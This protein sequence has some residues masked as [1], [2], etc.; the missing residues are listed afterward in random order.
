[1][2]GS[3]HPTLQIPNPQL[4]DGDQWV[5]VESKVHGDQTSAFHHGELVMELKQ[6]RSQRIYTDKK[7]IYCGCGISRC[8]SESIQWSS[9]VLQ[10][11]ADD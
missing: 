10:S 9:G 4:F 3:Y 7:E 11:S 1:M 8:N 6:T 5:Q 2:N